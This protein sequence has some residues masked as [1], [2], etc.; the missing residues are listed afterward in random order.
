M[1]SNTATHAIQR[2]LRLFHT[3]SFFLL[4]F[5]IG[6]MFFG[7]M[8]G[9]TYWWPSTKG[10]IVHSELVE[11][12]VTTQNAKN[13]GTSTHTQYTCLVAYTYKV[14]KN[15]YEVRNVWPFWN[16]NPYFCFTSF[17]EAVKSYSPDDAV[18]V[19]YDPQNVLQT[20]L[21]PGFTD[22]TLAF[23]AIFGFLLYVNHKVEKLRNEPFGDY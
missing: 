12:E 17:K 16:S 20:C 3:V 10:K 14:G 7:Y 19:Y 2:R 22:S 8:D 5:G 21:R 11:Q 23:F 13:G 4:L 15:E 9:R 1:S 6:A 18:D